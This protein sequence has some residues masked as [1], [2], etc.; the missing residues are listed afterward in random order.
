MSETR[1]LYPRLKPTTTEQLITEIRRIDDVGQM[2]WAAAHEDQVYAPIGGRRVAPDRLVSIREA[3]IAA[4]AAAE[5]EDREGSRNPHLSRTTRMDVHVGWALHG[6]STLCPTEAAHEPVWSWLTLVLLPDVA[7]IRFPD[8]HPERLRGVLRNTFRRVWWRA[9]VLGDLASPHTESLL[10][11][12]EYV[13]VFERVT[14]GRD[15]RLT[16]AIVRH[17]LY[18][19]PVGRPEY[20]RVF[21]RVLLRELVHLSVATFSDEEL[22]S[23]LKGIGATLHRQPDGTYIEVREQAVAVT[24]PAAVVPAPPVAP[25]INGHELGINERA[26]L[27]LAHTLASLGSRQVDGETLIKAANKRL[28]LESDRAQSAIRTLIEHG[29][30]EPDQPIPPAGY[31]NNAYTV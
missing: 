21:M 12:D 15:R 5:E 16:T 29:A 14:I 2:Q 17:L 23:Y 1:D 27:T 3:V 10:S 22:S 9:E 20:V 11:E 31:E 24:P 26:V 19:P 28:G 6:A 13:Q 30:I 18:L 25:S 7:S 8:K 4:V